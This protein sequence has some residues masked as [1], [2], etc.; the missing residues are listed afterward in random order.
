MLLL[1]RLPRLP[2]LHVLKSN[3]DVTKGPFTPDAVRVQR[4]AESSVTGP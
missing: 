3:A 1:A 4:V 2:V